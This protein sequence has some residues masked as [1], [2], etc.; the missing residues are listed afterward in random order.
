MATPTT[1]AATG[2]R[3]GL[4]RCAE[5]SGRGSSSG[6]GGVAAEQCA[7]DRG[8]G[9]ATVRR[10]PTAVVS[11][12]VSVRTTD[13]SA[14][15]GEPS[16]VAIGARLGDRGRGDVQPALTAANDESARRPEDHGYGS[17]TMTDKGAGNDDARDDPRRAVEMARPDP[18]HV[19]G[20]RERGGSR[21]ALAEAVGVA[22]SVEA[23]LATAAGSK[24]PHGGSRRN[25]RMLAGPRRH[26]DQR[27]PNGADRD[28]GGGSRDQARRVPGSTG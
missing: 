26:D 20:A 9:E 6:G 5:A 4:E 10:V 14:G 25:R 12:S 27:P 13:G 1:R 18:R 15:R 8:Q 21:E 23:E 17:R 2:A 3:H 24:W 19:D 7:N 11:M 28:R 22:R 16:R